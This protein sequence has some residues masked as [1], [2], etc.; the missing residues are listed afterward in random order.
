MII[1]YTRHTENNENAWQE[2]ETYYYLR[3]NK[4]KTFGQ[5]L[6]SDI[7][8]PFKDVAKKEFE[9]IFDDTTWKY[10]LRYTANANF[11]EMFIML[12]NKV[13]KI[14]NDEWLKLGSHYVNCTLIQGFLVLSTYDQN[15]FP[16]SRI[17]CDKTAV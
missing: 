13:L 17:K 9:L 2:T 1:R 8:I 7:T 4:T 6:T 11:S 15:F 10:I 12:H 5:D 16:I 3:K 14:S